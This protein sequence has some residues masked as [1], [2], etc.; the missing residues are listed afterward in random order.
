[1]EGRRTKA[2][3]LAPPQLRAAR[4][5]VGWSR[6]E[7]AEKSGTS[8]E[9]VKRFEIQGSD[10][11]RSTMIKWRSALAQVGVEFLD[12]TDDGKGE[13]VRFKSAKAKR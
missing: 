7:L 8:A 6:E 12:A 10:P 1:M 2:G 9:T 5:L 4:A 13:G 11:K 3:M